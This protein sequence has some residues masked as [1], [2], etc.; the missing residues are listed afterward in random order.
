MHITFVINLDNYP[1]WTRIP[2]TPV[3]IMSFRMRSLNLIVLLLS[4]Y[5]FFYLAHR[6]T[7]ISR[8]GSI[9]L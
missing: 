1:G 2:L 4:L 7:A 5:Q 9:S 3:A 8:L 6:T